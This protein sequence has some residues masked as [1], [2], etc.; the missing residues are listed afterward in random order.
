MRF[1]KA[2]KREFLEYL[3]STG[4]VSTSARAAG[5]TPWTAYDHRKKDEKFASEWEDAIQEACDYLENECR[6]RAVDG[7]EK[8]VF[9]QGKQCGSV[10]EY[11]DTLLIFLLKAHRP[12][13]FRDNYKVTVSED[14]PP[15]VKVD[16][17]K[18]SVEELETLQQ[19]MEKAG[20]E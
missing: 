10:Q 9:Y 7:V 19:I 6:R 17:S 14:V 8:P 11:S 2:V 16:Y 4:N 18:L 3:R 20:A 13:K 15:K 1:N 5:I 12:E